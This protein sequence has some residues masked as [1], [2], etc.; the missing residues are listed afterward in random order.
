MGN[1]GEG[2]RV[3]LVETWRYLES[4]SLFLL[5]HPLDFVLWKW[6]SEKGLG[7]SFLRQQFFKVC[8]QIKF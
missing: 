7:N 4:S 1:V 6:S 2:S 5:V 8:G 3:D